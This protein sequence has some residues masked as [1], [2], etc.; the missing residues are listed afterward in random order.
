ML[1]FACINRF[2]FP[3]DRIVSGSLTDLIAY[4]FGNLSQRTPPA[5]VQF[6]V[7]VQ[8]DFIA[9]G[10]MLS[11]IDAE[12][13]SQ[14]V[15]FAFSFLESGATIRSPS[16]FQQTRS[17]SLRQRISRICSSSRSSRLRPSNMMRPCGM[18]PVC[19]GKRRMIESA[20][21]D[22]PDPDS[23]TMATISPRPT[24]ET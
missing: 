13:S 4:L 15:V 3:H 22:L 18:R 7:V 8:A 16:I 12:M 14:T 2:D 21:T 6:F 10:V 20:E 23:P 17:E 24:T 9:K 19:R 5:S 1:P 11:E